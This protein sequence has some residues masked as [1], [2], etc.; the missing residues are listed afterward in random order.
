[1]NRAKFFDALRQD[2]DKFS[3]DQVA[4]IESII[5]ECGRRGADLGQ[6]AY[7]LA[8]ANGETGGK[9]RAVRE[10]MNYSESR[11]KQVFSVKRRQGIDPAKLAY[12]PKALANTVY[13]G[14]WGLENLGNRLGSTDG[15]DYRGFWIGQITGRHNAAKWGA[16]LGVDLTGPKAIDHMADPILAVKGL[17]APMLEGWATGKRLDQ[18]VKGNRRDYLDARQ[19]WNGTFEAAKYARYARSYERAL[20][21]SGYGDGA[22]RVAKATVAAKPVSLAPIP[23][24]PAPAPAPA[25]EKTETFIDLLRRLFAWWIALK[26]GDKK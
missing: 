10:N 23:Y 4:A 22:E 16:R 26:S 14:D 5:D 9:M 12:Q 13:G 17:V 21:V 2:G 1:M 6:A 20:I 7:I 24:A 11:I 18:Y 3:T 8:T 15:W 19:C 25:P